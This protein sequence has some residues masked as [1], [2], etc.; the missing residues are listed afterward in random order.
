MLLQ[1]Q[2]RN[3]VGDLQHTPEKGNGV[4]KMIFARNTF[5][6]PTGMN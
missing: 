2:G 1:C 4:W 3:Y 5:V 6:A